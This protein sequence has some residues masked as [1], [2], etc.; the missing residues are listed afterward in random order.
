VTRVVLSFGSNLGD[1]MAALTHAIERLAAADGVGIVALSPVYETAPIG[2]E[3]PD[4]L[5]AVAL[6]ETALPPYALLDVVH[7]VENALGRERRERWGPRTIDIDIVAYDGVESGDEQ[8]TLPHPHAAE[9]AFVL[10]P[11]MDV[12]PG[13]A[14]PDGRTGAELLADVDA[15][16]VHARPD[17]VLEV[18]A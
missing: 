12:E 13:F 14:L 2:P 7:E 17:L 11:W 10:V 5:N 9:R 4:Y 8:L 6:I 1:R 15:S 18:P 3:Q 16:G